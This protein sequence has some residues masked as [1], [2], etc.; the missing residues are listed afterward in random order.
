MVYLS[1]FIGCVTAGL[2]V[3]E[4]EHTLH[5]VTKYTQASFLR[6]F[7]SASSLRVSGAVWIDGWLG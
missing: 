3:E 1:Y 2:L 4:F 7:V 6:K 5:L